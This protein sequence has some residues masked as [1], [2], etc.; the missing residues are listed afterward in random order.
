MVFGQVRKGIRR[1]F[2]LRVRSDQLAREDGEDELR[3][4]V[5]ARVTQLISTGLTPADA[6]AEAIRRLGGSYQRAVDDMARS[7]R[8]REQTMRLH[9]WRDELRDDIRFAARGLRREKAF[10]TFIVA[11]LALGIGANAAMYGVIDRLL[12]RGPAHIVDAGRVLRVYWTANIPPRGDVTTRTFGWVTYDLLRRQGRSFDGVAAYAVRP[13]GIQY[14]EGASAALIPYGAATWDLFPTLRVQPAAGRFFTAQ[15][16]SPD[17]PQHVV[18]LSYGFWRRAFGGDTGAVGRTV[19]L[20]NA[21][22][23]IVGVAPRGFTGP[24][25]GPVDCWLPMSER[26]QTVTR[27]WTQAWNAQW[28]RVV[29]RLQPGVTAEQAG[30]D[31]TTIYRANYAGSEAPAKS[32]RLFLAPLRANPRGEEASET[33]ISRWLLG[34]TLAVLLIA[35]A[36]VANL[37]L[38]RALRRRRE[39]AVRVA[40]GAGRGRLVRLLLVESLLLAFAGGAAG[41]AVAWGT[42]TLLRSVLLT[43]IAWPSAPVDGRVLVVSLALAAVVG[44]LTGV[45]PAVRASRPELTAALKAG[46]REGGGQSSH[47]RAALTI[48]Q[49]ALSVV[50]LAS[51]GLFVRSLIRAHGVDL[52]F[53]PDR[54]F[55]VQPRYATSAGIGDRRSEGERTRRTQLLRDAVTRARTLPDVESASLTV[56]LP[57]Q[58]AFGLFQRV[59]GWDSLPRL[60]G[61]DIN[62]SAVADGYFE[63]VGTRVLAGRAFGPRDR[64]GSESVAI[65]NQTMARTL[66]PDRVP[67]GECLYWSDRPDSLTTCSRI[68]GVVAN[69][70]S[71]ALREQP[72]MHYYVPF[73]QERA[74]G[75]TSFVVRARRG[76]EADVIASVRAMFAA[77]DPT[78]TFVQADRMDRLVDPLIQPFRL[79]GTM[80]A[81]LGALAL[82]VASVGL[83]SVMSY[84]VA[85]R[86]HEIGVRIALGASGSRIVA[87]VL[88]S[89]VG[90]A[91]VGVSIG[92][93]IALAAGRFIQPLLFDTSARDPFVFVGVAGL[94]LVVA[95]LA[96]VLPAARARRVDPMQALRAE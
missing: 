92:M 88:R 75:G 19:T 52:G 87:L 58:S 37:L 1:L 94:L 23:T 18:V 25:L 2:H 16:D 27:N 10:T 9:N 5:D 76:R 4:Y 26:S 74:I 20:G 81:G 21:V 86:T 64:D 41:L 24:E 34:V 15:E 11:T 63:T 28:L 80:F 29:V 51:A 35:C 89:G 44:V 83:Y 7:A 13:G 77:M 60:A 38:A 43:G 17:A 39:I 55:V 59:A 96:S 14:G 12:L 56:G 36:N 67:I 65:V 22:Y 66:W 91:A 84:L 50:L 46:A 71:F 47:L 49:A 48:V 93:A 45:A 32:A 72:H 31:A 82:L 3:A 95:V 90:L 53:V 57:F 42:G 69:A 68:V 33:T 6:R 70:H 30:T 73:G 8:H 61:G 40:L 54:V 85:Q 62:I 79:G 78:I